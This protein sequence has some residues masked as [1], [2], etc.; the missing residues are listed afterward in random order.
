MVFS[1][2]LS[3]VMLLV[4]MCVVEENLKILLCISCFVLMVGVSVN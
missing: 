4:L 2:L 3:N 1:I